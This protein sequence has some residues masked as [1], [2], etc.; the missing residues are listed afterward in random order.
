MIEVVITS[1]IAATQAAHERSDVLFN[2]FINAVEG[3]IAD[4]YTGATLVFYPKDI[5]GWSK[6]SWTERNMT[7]KRAQA[8]YLTGGWKL[9]HSDDQREGEWFTLS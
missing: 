1:K 5:A 4:K 3:L 6:A 7:L 8:A 9:T 2:S